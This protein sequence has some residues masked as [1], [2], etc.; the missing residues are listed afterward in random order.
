MRRNCTK[1]PKGE[2]KGFVF[3]LT[4]TRLVDI[5]YNVIRFPDDDKKD[6]GEIFF[7]LFDKYNSTILFPWVL[8]KNK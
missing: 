1:N 2:I 6:F 4:S 5:N 7:I 3:F 8:S